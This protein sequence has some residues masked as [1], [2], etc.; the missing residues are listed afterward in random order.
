MIRQPPVPAVAVMLA[1]AGLFA[2]CA[3]PAARIEAGPG[4]AAV[5]ADFLIGVT[6]VS[7]GEEGQPG[8]ARYIMEADWI[9]RAVLGPGAHEGVYPARTRQL[10]LEQVQQVWAMV[11]SSPLADPR[12]PYRTGVWDPDPE[13]GDRRPPDH[14]VYLVFLAADGDR[15]LLAID[16]ATAPEQDV[17]VA[18]TV[19]ETLAA[20]AWVK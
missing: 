20:M 6:V 2:G 9:L 15:R 12:S 4:A 17:V 7:P 10:T 16:T 14:P 18:R 11:E 19:A 3:G 13:S 5:P 8:S 1:L